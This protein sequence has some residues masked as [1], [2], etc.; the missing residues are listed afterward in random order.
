[1]Y[2][3]C[4]YISIPI[5][6]NASLAI[7]PVVNAIML[8]TMLIVQIVFLILGP[9]SVEASKRSATNGMVLIELPKD[10][11][12][13]GTAKPILTQEGEGPTRRVTLDSFWM[14]V[15]EVSN[16]DFKEFVDNTGYE[17]EVR[18]SNFNLNVIFFH[19]L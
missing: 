8:S 13:M 15:H 5:R 11:F 2:I 19:L 7:L 10:G 17:T 4:M 14:D 1:M 12:I 18:S 9:V 3:T 6:M 16:A